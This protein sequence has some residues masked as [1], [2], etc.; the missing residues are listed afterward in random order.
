[1]K[2]VLERLLEGSILPK[3]VPDNILGGPLDPILTLVR[4]GVQFGEVTDCNL[5]VEVTLPEGWKV[6]ELMP[7]WFSLQDYKGRMR[8]L[9]FYKP[10]AHDTR[11][12]I[13]LPP[14]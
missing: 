4:A 11:A 3:Q 2:T 10:D 12:E 5:F 6:V 1:M 13:S 14:K 7:I 9:I 8:A